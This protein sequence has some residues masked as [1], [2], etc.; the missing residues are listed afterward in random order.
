[1]LLSVRRYRADSSV[2]PSDHVAAGGGDDEDFFHYD[3]ILNPPQH[4]A[5]PLASVDETCVTGVRAGSW[6]PRVRS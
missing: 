3:S 6:V 2:S 1:M 4:G 5:Q